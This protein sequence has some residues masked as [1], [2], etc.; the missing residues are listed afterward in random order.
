MQWFIVGRSKAWLALAALSIACAASAADTTATKREGEQLYLQMHQVLSH[1]RCMN[2][3][4]RGDTPSQGDA[5]T[6][7]VPTV[8][9]GATGNGA[10]GL[11][12]AAC[13]QATNYAASGVPGAANWHLAPL[14]MGWQGMTPAQL[15]RALVDKKR[16]GNRDTAALV[17]HLTED[18]LVAWGW[19]PGTDASGRARAPVPIPKAEFSRIVRAWAQAGAPCPQ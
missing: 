13:H 18:K 8:A 1:P 12:C 4:P 5:A 2:C 6:P 14:S 7:H 11:A 15:C 17:E 10:K 9:R 16:N 19:E 3:H